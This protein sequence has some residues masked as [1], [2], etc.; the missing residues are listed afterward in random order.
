MLKF[1]A[2]SKAG[3]SSSY[4]HNSQSLKISS[5]S[6]EKKSI[7]KFIKIDNSSDKILQTEGY[8]AT[9]SYTLS[10]DENAE[11]SKLIFYERNP[12]RIR[13]CLYHK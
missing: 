10:E 12:K 1:L 3:S 11:K 5:D 8:Q 9:I 4:K 6:Q 13:I 7:F 2:K